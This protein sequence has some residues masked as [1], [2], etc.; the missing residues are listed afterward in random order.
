MR[1]KKLSLL[2]LFTLCLALSTSLTS[3]SDNDLDSNGGNNNEGKETAQ[4]E[5]EK[6]EALTCLLGMVAELDSL[7]SNWND[8]NYSEEPTLGIVANAS[9]PYVRYVATNNAEEAN[10]QFCSMTASNF[11]GVATNQTWTKEGIGTMNFKV[12]N[13]T[14]CYAT[15]DVNIK[16]LPHLQQIRF[17]PSTAI[18]ENSSSWIAPKGTYY[19]FGDVVKQTIDGVET[20]WVC[21]RPCNVSPNLRK[22]HWCTFQLVSDFDKKNTNFKDLG[23]LILPTQLCSK[24]ADGA[25]MVQNLFNVM[26]TIINPE[27]NNQTT[28]PNLTGIDDIPYNK[29]NYD[30]ARGMCNLWTL[31]KIWDKVFTEDLKKS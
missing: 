18:G 7:P 24:E 3:C 23:N 28:Y 1:I 27:F 5:Y 9:E 2:S 17:V 12:L 20:Y 29:Y 30:Q 10:R 31:N 11:S 13:Q 15:V 22:T 26:R 4:V 25:R 21:V 19:S 6:H 16:Q 14:D 8:E